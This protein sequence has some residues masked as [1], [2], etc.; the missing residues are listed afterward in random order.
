MFDI[1]SFAG[2]VLICIFG[3]LYYRLDTLYFV[4]LILRFCNVLGSV[5][6]V[7]VFIGVDLFISIYELLVVLLDFVEL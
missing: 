5:L 4:I 3:L 7:L 1:F 2:F 6:C